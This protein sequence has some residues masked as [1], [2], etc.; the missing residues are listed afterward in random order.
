MAT[1]PGLS[2]VNRFIEVY[3]GKCRIESGDDG[4]GISREDKKHLFTKGFG[5][6]TGLGLFLTKE[7]LAI[8]GM[9][10]REAGSAGKGARFEIYV[11]KGA[12]RFRGTA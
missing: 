8:T 1:G 3:G 11:P 9:E 4:V 12:Y 6:N 10:I 5:K 2:T 7:I